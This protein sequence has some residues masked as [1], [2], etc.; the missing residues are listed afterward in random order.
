MKKRLAAVIRGIVIAF[1][2]DES[3]DWD[4]T[5]WTVGR[6]DHGRARMGACECRVAGSRAGDGWER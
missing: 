6:T 5:G 3:V 1:L 4:G 2:S